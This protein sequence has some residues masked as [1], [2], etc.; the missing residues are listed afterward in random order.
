MEK[1]STKRS[2]LLRVRS[3]SE[4][5]SRTR[6]VLSEW[7]REGKTREEGN[8]VLL[9]HIELHIS[10]APMS[11]QTVI[12]GR[13]RVPLDCSS[14]QRHGEYSA[15]EKCG[16]TVRPLPPCATESIDLS[17]CFLRWHSKPI[18]C[19]LCVHDGSLLRPFGPANGLCGPGSLAN[20]LPPLAKQKNLSTS[21]RLCR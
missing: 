16:E 4:R 3:L 1:A 20:G 14:S 12:R 19:V 18:P 9:S 8:H 5:L 11:A 17:E 21:S 7:P 10:T 15:H 13:F 6:A 2:G